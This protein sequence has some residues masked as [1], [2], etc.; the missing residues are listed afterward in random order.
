M[1]IQ[2]YISS[3]IIE[4]Y[5]L[6]L[7][8]PEERKEFERLAEQYPELRN[9]R[10]AFGVSL[11]NNMQFASITPPA[12][13]KSKIFSEIDIQAHETAPSFSGGGHDEPP[14]AGGFAERD[15]YGGARSRGMVV[16]KEFSRVLAAAAVV[17]L[18]MSTALNFYFFYRYK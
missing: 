14:V 12:H 3:G 10:D 17:F 15:D 8:D 5:V 1:N 6:G 18:L 7:A 16:R 11:E 4:S 13:I 2:E 9:A